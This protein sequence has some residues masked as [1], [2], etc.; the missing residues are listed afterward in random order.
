[1]ASPSSPTALPPF[2]CAYT[3]AFAELVARLDCA[4]LLSTYQAGKLI[5]LSSDG[6]RIIQLPRTFHVPMGVAIDGQRMAVA[7]EQEVVVLADEPELAAT[8]PAKPGTYDA[9]FVPR[10]VYFTGQLN[11]HDMAWVDDRLIAVNTSFS[12]LCEINAA[13]SFRPIWQPP[14]ITDLQHEDRCHLNGMA[15]DETGPRYATAFAPTD[16][17]Q[18]WRPTKTHSG[19][20]LDVAANDVICAD[21][22]MPH[23]P[24]LIDDELYLLLSATGEIVRVDRTHGDWEVVNRLNGFVRGLERYGDYLFVGTSRLRKTHTFGDL[25][26]AQR[27]DLFCG[28]TAIHLPTGAIVGQLIYQNSCE[29]IYDVRI[30]PGRHRPNI[31]NHLTPAHRTAVTIP[32]S[33]FWGATPPPSAAP[34]RTV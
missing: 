3:P 31:L 23:S 26:L 21:L 22:P 19:I 4:L 8:Y 18:G 17:A 10:A 28:V 1:M 13:H 9:L 33:T 34:R 15:V 7:T 2:S 12:C 11:L 25:E 27:D 16:T 6:E 32:G 14:F 29:E 30:L 24:R 20:L 5:T